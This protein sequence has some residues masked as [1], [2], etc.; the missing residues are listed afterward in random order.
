[1]GRA[2]NGEG[3]ISGSDA[4]DYYHYKVQTSVI[5]PNGSPYVVH[6]TSTI[7]GEDAKKKGLKKKKEAERQEKLSV[8]GKYT[9]KETFQF[10]VKAFMDYKH[11]STV[12]KNRWV[13]STYNA[14][15][16]LMN[17]HFFKK[18]I[19]L[20]SMQI[21]SLNVNVFQEYYDMLALPN[22]NGDVLGEK[23]RRNIKGVLVKTIAFINKNGFELENYADRA[24]VPIQKTDE[25]PLDYTGEDEEKKAVF[26]EEDIQKIWDGAQ[27]NI[28]KY[29]FGYALMLATGIRS[30]ELFGITQDL[31]EIS[32]DK[33]SGSIKICKAV[34]KRRN[35]V[36]G[37][38]ERYLKTTKN[39]DTRI[40]Y[41]DR[42]GVE[43]VEKLQKAMKF[44]NNRVSNDKNLLIYDF[45]GDF[46]NSDVFGSE[47]HRFCLKFG[48][49]LPENT[50]PHMLRHTFVTVNNVKYDVNPLIT[51][52]AAGHRDLATDIKTYSHV[53]ED[54]VRKKIINPF[55]QPNRD[56]RTE[57]QEPQVSGAS[58]DLNKLSG[59]D[60]QKA[61]D[62]YQQLKMIFEK[63]EDSNI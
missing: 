17:T 10:W 27:S 43:C 61:F 8:R 50:G 57:V 6:T 39:R 3:S 19:R 11:S 13:D 35:P 47:F 48:I 23:S 30:Q 26:D 46:V 59:D 18:N 1:M 38:K 9:G 40:V 45:K 34:A 58:A 29:G 60:L 42:C 41:L 15:C 49:D 5:N 31:I 12:T 28:F 52:Y 2:K 21:H 54:D 33:S 24:Y 32:D 7:S 63:N 51:A 56:R 4:R 53:S 62:L 25:V 22:E 20:K 55:N 37:K 14:Y 36:T 44:Y 16:N